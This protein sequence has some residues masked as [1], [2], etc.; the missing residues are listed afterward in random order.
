MALLTLA[1]CDGGS[2]YS[3]EKR[4]KEIIA[5]INDQEIP[6]KTYLTKLRLFKKMYR[7]SGRDKFDSEQF[8]LVKSKALR[9]MVQETL[10]QQEAQK[11]QISV[12]PGEFHKVLTQAKN[13]L[14]EDSFGKHV[15][16]KGVTRQEWENQLKNNELI[17]KLINEAVNS[18]VTVQEEELKAYFAKNQ[19]EFHTG[20]QVRALH[21]MVETEEEA[22]D[23]LKQLDS[24][25]KSF[26]DLARIY[27]LSPEGPQGGDLGYFEAGQMP[28]VIDSVFK[29]KINQTSEVILTPYG[30]HIFK[31]IDKKKDRK[32]TFEE[33]R[34]KIHA[35]LLR[36]RR[37]KAFRE[38]LSRLKEKADIKVHYDVLAQ[39]H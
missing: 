16:M 38:W 12:T 10:F 3:E 1:G 35:N 27:S 15:E 5:V 32:R 30:A 7:I 31:V 9:E 2:D 18:K 4:G 29:L 26:S 17:K 13:G 8:L 34:K 19:E 6:V 14:D 37:D 36:E 11:Q 39:I 22:R 21:I 23:I 28:A 24:K 25:G 20:E 33:S